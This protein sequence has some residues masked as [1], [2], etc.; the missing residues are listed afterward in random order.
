MC[1]NPI[2]LRAR[3]FCSFVRRAAMTSQRPTLPGLFLFLGVLIGGLAP[4]PAAA[5]LAPGHPL[6]GVAASPGGNPSVLAVE[7]TVDGANNYPTFESPDRSIDGS[8][9]TKYLN[10]ART[11]AGFIVTIPD[12]ARA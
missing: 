3:R 8:T 6:V 11:N 12:G 4:A 1:V 7:G 10:F 9:G 5:L 2:L